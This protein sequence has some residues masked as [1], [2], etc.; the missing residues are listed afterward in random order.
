DEAVIAEVAFDLGVSKYGADVLRT[1]VRLLEEKRGLD[2][3]ERSH[4]RSPLGLILLG[5]EHAFT[6]IENLLVQLRRQWRAKALVHYLEFVGEDASCVA[7]RQSLYRRIE[8]N[9]ET[10]HDCRLRR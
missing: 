6:A 2:S 5:T 10:I 1:S 9:Q 7:G 3:H 4:P 8:A